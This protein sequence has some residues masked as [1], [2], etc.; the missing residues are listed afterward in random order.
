AESRDDVGGGAEHRRGERRE[1]A[2]ELVDRNGVAALANPRELRL[3]EARRRWDHAVRE[4][5]LAV[6]GHVV[7]DAPTDPVRRA[8]EVA[9]VAL[10]EMLDTERRRN[11]EVDRLAARLGEPAQRRRREVDEVGFGDVAL[12]EAEQHR[13]GPQAPAAGDALQEALA[14]E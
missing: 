7:R 9:R 11:T 1:T 13:P 5:D 2:L 3:V 8:D 4:E 12:R 6:R 10:R 14:P